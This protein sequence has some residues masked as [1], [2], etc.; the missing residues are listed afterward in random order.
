MT[1][2]AVMY[3]LSD[4]MEETGNARVSLEMD[5]DDLVIRVPYLSGDANDII[6][7]L[8]TQKDA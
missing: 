2:K 5:K 6:K 4:V 1:T 7:A 3:D 8:K